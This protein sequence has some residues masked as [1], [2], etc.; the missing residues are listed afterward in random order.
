MA[1]VRTEFTGDASDLQRASA[2]AQAALD[3]VTHASVRAEKD[4][5]ALGDASGKTGAAAGK[6]AGALGLV[7]PAAA[8][9]AATL[10]DLAD[11]GEVG[12]ASAEALGLSLTVTGTAVAALS[13]AAILGY[14]VWNTYAVS[15]AHAAAQQ[16]RLNSVMDAGESATLRLAGLGID[17]AVANGKM[18]EEEASYQRTLLA[19]K[20]ALEE[21]AVAIQKE[22]GLTEMQMATAIEAADHNVAAYNSMSEAQKKAVDLMRVAN[23]ESEGVA[24]FAE[25]IRDAKLEAKAATD[26]LTDSTLD[27]V[28]ADA[29]WAKVLAEGVL[30]NLEANMEASRKRARAERENAEII[31]SATE[32]TTARQL[33]AEEELRVRRIEM[34]EEQAA[35]YAQGLEDRKDLDQQYAESAV[36]VAQASLSFIEDMANKELDMRTSVIEKLQQELSDG[37]DT[38]TDSQKAALEER[39]AVNKE[40]A[41]TAF[42]IAKGVA[43]AQG[44][45]ATALAVVQ[46]LASPV[47]YPVAAA[48]AVAAGL[49]GAAS[50]A[51]IASEPPPTFH[52]GGVFMP[53]EGSAKLRAGEGVLTPETT[54]NVGGP[55]GISEMNRR[56]GIAGSPART[57][58]IGR[59]EVAEMER[60][61]IRA[62]G[63]HSRELARRTGVLPGR[64][65]RGVRV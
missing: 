62:N 63:P 57:I 26:A 32:D 49:A 14:G 15:A 24:I 21:K 12:A 36:A 23:A 65:G 61:S 20:K 16:D 44:A 19:S 59:L 7:S 11:V 48:F 28:D 60:T 17:L 55:A 39:I 3:N 29:A 41:T 25:K 37:E 56:Q 2:K 47:P 40:A 45:V 53:D 18:T 58:R 1:E 51:V 33:E 34:A 31:A 64:S 13:A 10:A 38:L 52:V 9:A 35:Q 50:V 27:A 46:A 43:V 22:T 30:Y 4:I 42:N 5:K 54:R 8:S 6:L